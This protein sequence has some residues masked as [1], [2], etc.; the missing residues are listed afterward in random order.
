M[1]THEVSKSS[2]WQPARSSNKLQESHS[3]LII[4]FFHK[5]QNNN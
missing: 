5:L 4:Y 1:R 3:L 2:H